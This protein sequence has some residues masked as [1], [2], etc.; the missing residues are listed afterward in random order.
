MNI[1][2]DTIS[3]VWNVI[4]FNENRKIVDKIS[5]DFKRNESSKL[6]PT[7]TKILQKNFLEYNSLENIIVVNGPWSFTWIRSTILVVNSINFLI[8]KKITTINF[9]DLFDEYP[10][11]KASSK[12]DMFIKTNKNS[13]I[14][15]LDNK[16]V[17]LFLKKA[18]IKKVYWDIEEN[19]FQD[20]QIINFSDYEKIIKNIKFEN[21]KIAESNYIKKP[22]IT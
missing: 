22:N 13:Q 21:L 11:L 8:N 6:I 20:V 18:N 16:E 10:I 5:L 4:L 17:D 9:F 12:R 15:I 14:K 2:I 7:I 3:K 19:F 1:F